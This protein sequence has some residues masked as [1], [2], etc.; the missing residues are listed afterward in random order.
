V[1]TRTYVGLYSS[2]E[3]DLNRRTRLVEGHGELRAHVTTESVT[4]Q[5]REF[6]PICVVGNDSYIRYDNGNRLVKNKKALKLSRLHL[7]ASIAFPAL[8]I[9][10]ML[11]S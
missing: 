11:T 4:M 7:T 8:C 10:Q 3:T 9:L 6:V 1:Y 5:A 2:T